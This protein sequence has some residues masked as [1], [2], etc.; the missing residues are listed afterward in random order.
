MQTEW[1]CALG[2][3]FDAQVRAAQ[4]LTGYTVGIKSPSGKFHMN[5]VRGFFVYAA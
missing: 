1:K 3:G 5:F 4:S 2:S